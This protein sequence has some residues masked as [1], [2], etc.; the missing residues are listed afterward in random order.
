[1]KIYVCKN[2]FTLRGFF[3]VYPYSEVIAGL[4]RMWL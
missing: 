3:S 1:M 2:K 4:M